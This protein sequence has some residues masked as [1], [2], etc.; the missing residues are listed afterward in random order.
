MGSKNK[1][2]EKDTL[3]CNCGSTEFITRPNRYDIYKTE[4]K[5]VIF[6]TSEIINDKIILF[7]RECSEILNVDESDIII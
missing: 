4:K 7:C 5:K 1:N 6:Q 3:S 2:K